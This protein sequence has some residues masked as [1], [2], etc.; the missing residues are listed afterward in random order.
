MA[1]IF[2]NLIITDEGHQA[3]VDA[4]YN[5]ANIELKE[6]SYSSDAY[7]IITSPPTTIS[8]NSWHRST[9]N[10][11]TII[12]NNKI[13]VTCVVEALDA[14][15]ATTTVGLYLVDGTLFAL[16]QPT[17]PMSALQKQLFEIQIGYT[18][19]G[20]TVN[21]TYI[22]DGDRAYLNGS[23][24]ELFQVKDALIGDHAINKRIF[25][26]SIVPN[27]DTGAVY[28]EGQIFISDSDI[29]YQ[30]MFDDGKDAWVEIGKI[31]TSVNGTPNIIIGDDNTLL[32]K[33]DGS[34]WGTGANEFGELGLGDETKREIFV[35]IG[36]QAK[37]IGGGYDSFYLIKPD[38]TLWA[39]GNNTEGQLG[40][41]DNLNKNVFTDTG[42]ASVKFVNGGFRTAFVIKEDDTL[43]ATGQNLSGELGL[44]D[45]L[46]KNVF[47]DTGIGSVKFAE[48]T[49]NASMIIKIDGTLWGTGDDTQ[50]NMNIG[51]LPVNIFTNTTFSALDVAMDNTSTAIVQTDGKV[52]VT[53]IGLTGE[54]GL[55]ITTSVNVFTDTGLAGAVNVYKDI[56][57][58]IAIKSDGSVWGTGGNSNGEL[59]QGDTVQRDTFTDLGVTASY[60]TVGYKNTIIIDSDGVAFGAGANLGGE[61]GLG[62]SL[63]HTTFTQL[64]VSLQA[65]VEDVLELP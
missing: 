14:S 42:V 53:G 29:A 57:Q 37:A 4:N 26:K 36:I 16:A 64:D 45:N 65:R 52:L 41:G 7:D 12:D 32:L 61:F 5:G 56:L 47:T 28:A 1:S 3:L 34:V 55:G 59:G 23:A 62:D 33:S 38:G 8:I 24:D 6:F 30:K 2:G 13:K 17:Y 18:N 49:L 25:D 60:I 43:W 20:T 27:R 63:A 48:G 58:M 51:G 39:S 35:P 21:F 10:S 22:A 31:M 44:G 15:E 54:L 50:N 46:S 11:A 9:I 40:I 19:I